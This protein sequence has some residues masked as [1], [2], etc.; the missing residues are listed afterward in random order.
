MPIWEVNANNG[1]PD[2]KFDPVI[3]GSLN[4]GYHGGTG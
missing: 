3:C 2:D 4:Y 1:G